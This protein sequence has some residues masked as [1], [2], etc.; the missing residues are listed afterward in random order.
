MKVG[1]KWLLCLGSARSVLLEI[2]CL[3][4]RFIDK[5]G[6]QSTL[7]NNLCTNETSIKQIY[8]STILLVCSITGPLQLVIHGVQNC[9]AGEQ[10]SHW[11]KT[12]KEN[13]HFILCMSFV[14]LVPVRLLLSSMAVFYLRMASCK[15]PISWLFSMTIHKPSTLQR[16]KLDD[17][18]YSVCL[19]ESWPCTGCFWE[20]SLTV[21]QLKFRQG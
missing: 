1:I 9:R 17:S 20:I 11:D 3:I 13:Y 16:W 7:N 5:N 8:T 14:C 19:T 2:N 18:F 15:G 6:I 10:M 4:Y 21:A 12:N